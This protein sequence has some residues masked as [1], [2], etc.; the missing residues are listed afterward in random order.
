MTSVRHF[1]L[2]TGHVKPA[3]VEPTGTKHAIAN[4]NRNYLRALRAAELN[5]WMASGGDVLRATAA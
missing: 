5:A 1:Q 4:V 3:A 2:G